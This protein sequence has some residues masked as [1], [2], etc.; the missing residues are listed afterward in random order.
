MD[1]EDAQSCVQ[2]TTPQVV[3][4]HGGNEC[5]HTNAG[6]TIGLAGCGRNKQ[7]KDKQVTMVD[8]MH[9]LLVSGLF[10]AAGG[11]VNTLAS[12]KKG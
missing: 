5:S 6:C 7:G 10:A 2:G 11:A 12:R 1:M 8:K 3:C 4:G 9:E